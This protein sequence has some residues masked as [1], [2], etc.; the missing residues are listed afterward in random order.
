MPLL[1][2]AIKGHGNWY[3]VASKRVNGPPRIP[4]P[5]YLGKPEDIAARDRPVLVAAFGALAAPV[6]RSPSASMC[7]GSLVVPSRNDPRVGPMGERL[8]QWRLGSCASGPRPAPADPPRKT[9]GSWDHRRLRHA[10]GNPRRHQVGRREHSVLR[11]IHRSADP[12]KRF[13]HFGLAAYHAA[14]TQVV[15]QPAAAK[16]A[17]VKNGAE[18][19]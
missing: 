2:Q 19:R 15:R 8:A 16:P 9:S 7:W 11:V 12:D 17:W 1:K 6:D 10:P 3:L 5:L 4:W 13:E 18:Y 14:L